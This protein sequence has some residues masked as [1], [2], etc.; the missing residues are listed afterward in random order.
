MA[1][2]S[3]R[4]LLLDCRH[5]GIEIAV[6]EN[7]LMVKG[8]PERPDLYGE[9]K[10]RKADIIDAFTNLPE[11]V[12]IHYIARLRKG[13]EWIVT[14][15]DKLENSTSNH[16]VSDSVLAQ[17]KRMEE[18]LINNMMK[19]ALLDQELRRLY[20]EFTGCPMGGCE[21]YH[22]RGSVIIRCEECAE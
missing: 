19:W 10:K 8:S 1:R 11:A 9:I 6:K 20:P 3:I 16:A 12:E 14:C 4:Q 15:I 21:N 17:E 7:T 22:V 5:V 13:M 18:A 2:D